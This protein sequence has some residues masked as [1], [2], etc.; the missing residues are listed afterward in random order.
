MRPKNRYKGFV[1]SKFESIINSLP[2]K[3][4][5][6]SSYADRPVDPNNIPERDDDDL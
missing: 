1:Q 3:T 6:S 4:E 5:P 2:S